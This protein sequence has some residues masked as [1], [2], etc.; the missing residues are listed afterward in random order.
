M[1]IVVVFPPPSG[2][3]RPK[4][5]PECTSKLR[6]C[7]ARTGPKLLPSETTSMAGRLSAARSA[8]VRSMVV[9]CGIAAPFPLANLNADVGGHAR[10]EF[11][12]R[13]VDVNFYEINQG[14]ALG[15]GLHGLRSE[16]RL[17]RNE[18]YAA[19]I[20]FAGI[21]VRGDGAILT[22]VNFAEICFRHVHLHPDVRQIRERVDR[23]AGR[24]D[25]AEFG[26]AHGDHA[27]EWRGERGVA[28]AHARNSRG[29]NGLVYVGAIDG[30]LFF[31]CS[32]DEFVQGLLLA[33]ER[34]LRAL[35]GGFG[36]IDGLAFD[37]VL[38]KERQVAIVILLLLIEIILSVAHILARLRDVLLAA[39]GF[40]QIKFAIAYFDIGLIGGGLLAVIGAVD[41][42]EELTGRHRLA[43]F[44]RKL[45][46][47]A[48]HFEAHETLV[49]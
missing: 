5:S 10:F 40:R 23:R 21:C 30:D 36:L 49:R 9:P 46:D 45:R 18:R 16:F 14:D 4:I 42:R 29:L 43:F 6:S 35:D 24:D 2:P 44:D 33:I 32:F 34:G 3:T 1:R 17:R 13:V 11:E 28:E 15:G 25:F 20:G 22:P 7:T 26:F 38:L 48:G 37:F 12:I 41:L 19:M 27:V 39:A 31:A 8:A 47:A